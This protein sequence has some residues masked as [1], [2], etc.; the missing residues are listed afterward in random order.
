[1][2][3]RLVALD[4]KRATQQESIAARVGVLRRTEWVVF[5]FLL[6]AQAVAFLLPGAPDIRLRACLIDLGVI[7]IGGLLVLADAAKPTLAV[8]VIRDWFALAVLLLAYQE[9]GWFTVPHF[10]NALESQWVIWDRV[11][12]RGGAKA[13]I[14][15]FG[16]I[17]PSILD[18]SYFLV[19]TLGP[20]SVAVLYIYRKRVR[21]DR[22]LFTFVLSV[23]LCY[24]QFPFWPSQPPRLLFS[25][26]DVPMCDTIFRRFNWW[27]LG[28]YS[29]H[30]S[31]FPSAH[32]AGAFACAFSMRRALPEHKW[33]S[34]LLWV[35]AILIATATVYG[36]YHYLADALAGL[37]VA[38]L[39]TALVGGRREIQ[40]CPAN[41]ADETSHTARTRKT[42][43]DIP[44]AAGGPPLYR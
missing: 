40:R 38:A 27:M 8:S 4:P 41:P 11:V 14:E 17:L 42:E 12:L 26:E 18:I 24:V 39:V 25:G 2:A 22:F 37:F 32:V 19:Y 10:G 30:T 29:I 35:L 1:V 5:V 6:Y 9:M 15:A 23:L 31:V 20:F 3:D 21:V 33:V 7:A 43:G 16:P 34:R 44:P 36:R 28:N 13:A